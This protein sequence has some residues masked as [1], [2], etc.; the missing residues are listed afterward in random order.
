MQADEM[1]FEEVVLAVAGAALEQ[2][3][4]AV[5]PFRTE[6]G[7]GLRDEEAG[8]DLDLD[9]VTLSAREAGPDWREVVDGWVGQ[10]LLARAERLH[11]PTEAELR[12]SIRTRLTVADEAR[13]YARE[14]AS[15]LY[16]ALAIDGATSVRMLTDA[17]LAKSPIDID[18]LYRLGQ[19]NTDA[20]PVDEVFQLDDGVNGIAGDSF[21]IASKVSNFPALLDIIG[22][23]PLGAAFA[24]VNRSLV[25]YTV[26]AD[27]ETGW[28]GPVMSLAQQVSGLVNDEEFD[29]PGGLLTGTTFYW[30]PDGRVEYLARQSMLLEGEPT[31]TILPGPAFSDFVMAAS[32]H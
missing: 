11:E 31:I 14:F 10:Y 16:V 2:N 4:V 18:E 24:P 30:A 20:E 22:P 32:T 26:I 19:A 3:G 13:S 17:S 21:F 29:H 28:M 1:G 9:N 7:Y 23:A 25:L 15:D 5:Q 8:G 6:T 12:S 27:S